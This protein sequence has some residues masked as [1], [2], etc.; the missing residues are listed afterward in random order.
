MIDFD[1]SE[2]KNWAGDSGADGIF[3]KL[4]ANLVMATVS[5]LSHVD[6]PS[7]SAVWM[8]GWDGILSVV[9]GN[10]WIPVGD[11][12]CEF[13][14]SGSPAARANENYRKRTRRPLRINRTTATFI[15]FT[16]R[17]WDAE[18]KRQ[19]IERRRRRDDW[20]DVRAYDATDLVNWLHSAPA[21][22]D[23][24]ARLIGKLPDDGYVCL[25][26]WWNNWSTGTQPTIKP[27][28]AL[29]GRADETAKAM[30]WL[31]GPAVSF[32]VA[33]DTRDEAIGF[34][35]A[36]ALASGNHVGPACLAKAV[37]AETPDAWRSLIRRRNPMVLIRNFE[38]DAS[39]Q[40]ATSN[41]HHV[42][43]PLDRSQ[44]PR[45]QGLSFAQPWKR[46]DSGSSQVDGAFRDSRAFDVT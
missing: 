32:Y 45:G 29:A 11:V 37:V 34:L 28:L 16:P 46:G 33:G 4:I 22:A 25:N 40:V 8:P 18:K 39:S 20:A 12:A 24:F 31:S 36:S 26:D 17:L 23:W 13:S 15:F 41:G 6:I 42:V 21:V 10:E 3:P 9:E 7:G 35:A 44:E 2:I 5:E 14:V 27:E 30:D 19:W 38:G 43:I 1:A